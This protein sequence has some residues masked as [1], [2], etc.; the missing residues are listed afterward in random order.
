MKNLEKIEEIERQLAPRFHEVDRVACINQEK[1]LNAFR[2]VGVSNSHF[3]GTTG[4]GYTDKGRDDFSK[5]VAKVFG[6]E[7]ALCSPHLTCGTHTIAT[8][9]YGLLRPNDMMIS[10]SGNLYDTLENTLFG[11]DN[12][13][14][15]SLGVKFEFIDLIG[16]EF[17]KDK[18]FSEVKKHKPR[19]VF[20]Q[21]SRGYSD[22]Q[23]ISVRKMEEIFKEVKKISP[24]TF[25]MVDNCY[26]EFVE[27][28]EPTN[29]GA[30]VCMGSFIKNI[31][32]SLA[33]TGGYIVG[34]KRA[35]EKIDNRLTCPSLGR[36]TGSYEMGYRLFY[37][38]LFMAPHVVAQALK[39]GYLIGE[40]MKKKGMKVIPDSTEKSYD[41]VKS[42]V[43]GDKEKLIEFVQLIQK[44]SPIDS[45]AVPE[46]YPMS[47]YNCDV[48]M[49]AGTFVEGASIELS[50]D[51]PIRPPYIAYFQGGITYEQLKLIACELCD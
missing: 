3:C 4:Y 16:N 21:K 45:Y 20:V 9:L 10:I 37:Q 38:G 43:F 32:G 29:V 8:A 39:G 31:G 14:L 42:I 40:V 34:S 15:Q 49:A 12:G 41:I 50:C 6:A 23:A 27:D 28:I 11:E 51:S 44:L 46:P 30:D 18:I 24:E 22:R 25:I 47:G 17:D 1:V 35:I 33:P 26:G 36:E 13:S 5:V 7:D 2:E 19:V 48:I